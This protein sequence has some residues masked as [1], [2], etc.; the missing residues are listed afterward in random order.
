[1]RLE[2]VCRPGFLILV[3]VLLGS[4]SIVGASSKAYGDSVSGKIIELQTEDKDALAILGKGVVGD[5]L[6]AKPIADT[7]RLMPLN[8]GKWTYRVLAG[9]HKDTKQEDIIAR[10]KHEKS[11]KSWRRVVGKK[12]IEYFRVRNGGRIEIASEV[13]LVEDVITYYTPLLCVLALILFYLLFS[14]LVHNHTGKDV[15]LGKSMR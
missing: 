14:F 2:N 3:M 8:A 1:M 10:P 4:L 15:Y 6:P 7:A 11:G 12:C 9:D 13:D 5:A